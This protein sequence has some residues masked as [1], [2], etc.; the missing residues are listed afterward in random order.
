MTKKS[1][2]IEEIE[3]LITAKINFEFAVHEKGKHNMRQ[4]NLNELG[5]D[6]QN[7]SESL[8]YCLIE[9]YKHTEGNK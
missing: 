7:T 2:C 4:E 5:R 3:N 9:N 6:I 1:S 8:R